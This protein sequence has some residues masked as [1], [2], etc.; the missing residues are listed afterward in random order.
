MLAGRRV[1]QHSEMS[2]PRQVKLV[3]NFDKGD[4]PKRARMEINWHHWLNGHEYEQTLGD[5][6]GQRSLVCCSPLGRRVGHKWA[7]E[8]EKG[9]TDIYWPTGKD[10]IWGYNLKLESVKECLCLPH[11]GQPSGYWRP[12]SAHLVAEWWGWARKIAVLMFL[13][14]LIILLFWGK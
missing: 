7:T 6:G 13:P 3:V 12:I 5:S 9:L 11:D 2:F 8:Q 1:K 10:T 4:N 14:V